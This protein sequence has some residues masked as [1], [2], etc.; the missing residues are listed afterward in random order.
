MAQHR[1]LSTK[2]VL[3]PESGIILFLVINRYVEYDRFTFQLLYIMLLVILKVSLD[4][5]GAR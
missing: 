5:F 3:F 4:I 2:L 1:E